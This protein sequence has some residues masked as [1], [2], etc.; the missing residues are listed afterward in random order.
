MLDAHNIVGVS[1]MNDGQVVETT[2][3]GRVLVEGEG[4]TTIRQFAQAVQSSSIENSV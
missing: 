4:S 1:D 3:C 2:V